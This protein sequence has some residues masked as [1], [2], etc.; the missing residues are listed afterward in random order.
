[1]MTCQEFVDFIMAYLETELP[2]EQH[3]VFESHLNACPECLD[4]LE[5][6]RETVALG[7][8]VCQI[9][10]GPI[11]EDVP[12]RLVQAILAARRK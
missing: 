9:P 10:Q 3:S 7:K 4:Y 6:Y 8:K 12:E 11:P 2:E 1:M 5:S